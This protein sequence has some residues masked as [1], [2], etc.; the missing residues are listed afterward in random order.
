MTAF[1]FALFFSF[2]HGQPQGLEA[3]AKPGP[4]FQPATAGGL[5]GAAADGLDGDGTALDAPGTGD[6]TK[7]PCY[8]WAR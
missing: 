5:D 7:E 1:W 8:D 4:I 6:V 3:S 2:F